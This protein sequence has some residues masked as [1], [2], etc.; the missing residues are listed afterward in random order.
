MAARLR[1]MNL[2]II[3][4]GDGILVVPPYRQIPNHNNTTVIGGKDDG[5]SYSTLPTTSEI[6]LN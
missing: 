5:I 6:N 1:R 3:S 4:A 2:V